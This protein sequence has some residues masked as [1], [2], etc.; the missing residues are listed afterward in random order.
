MR[1]RTEYSAIEDEF[2]PAMLVA[3]E[4]LDVNDTKDQV[5]YEKDDGDR[6]VR[7]NRRC[8]TQAGVDRRIWR[9]LSSLPRCSSLTVVSYA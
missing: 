4:D 5:E 3:L 9:A 2:V 1:D 6:Y 7:H 8:S